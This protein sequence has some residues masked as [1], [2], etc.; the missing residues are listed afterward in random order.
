MASLILAMLSIKIQMQIQVVYRSCWLFLRCNN[1]MRS[2]KEY[3]LTYDNDNEGIYMGPYS[4]TDGYTSKYESLL[5]AYFG[6][7]LL[8]SLVLRPATNLHS[9]DITYGF[10][11]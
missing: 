7:C 11:S 5:F 8:Y 2:P 10:H 6:L 1:M 3:I 9:L 4:S